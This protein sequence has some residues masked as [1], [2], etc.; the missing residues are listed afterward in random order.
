MSIYFV[1]Y[2]WFSCILSP[3]D[4]RLLCDSIDL[5]LTDIAL[6]FLV[7][8]LSER[9]RNSTINM[10]YTTQ[11]NI[12]FMSCIRNRF[13]W[14]S[15]DN[16]IIISFFITLSSIFVL[17]SFYFIHWLVKRSTENLG[18]CICVASTRVNHWFLRWLGNL[19]YWLFVLVSFKSWYNLL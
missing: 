18:D 8:L 16:R 10:T 7:L 6:V 5:P 19:F 11:F 14:W 13:V 2:C 4:F 9:V 12:Y 1:S 3:L 15:H 17:W